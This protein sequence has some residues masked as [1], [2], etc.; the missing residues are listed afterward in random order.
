MAKKQHGEEGYRGDLNDRC[1]TIAEVLRTAGYATY[2][3]G[4]WHVTN[5][6]SPS[7]AKD[8]WPLQR[9]FDHF[10][11]TIMG[12]GSYYDPATLCRG[13]DYITPENDPAYRPKRSITPTP[14]PTTPCNFS[15]RTTT[16]RPESRFSCI[17]LHGSPLADA[18]SGR[19]GRLLS[20]RLR[21]GLG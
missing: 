16:G 17:C 18:G 12:G 13:N 4:K 6:L 1:V 21:Q 14:L 15:P 2:A 20:R 10:Y 3:V 7:G 8:N 5:Q 11:G 19:R 9:G